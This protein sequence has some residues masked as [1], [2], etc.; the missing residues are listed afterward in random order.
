MTAQDIHALSGAY[1]VDALDDIER[2]RFEEHLAVCADCRDEVAGLRDS[3][4]MLASLTD[5][6]PPPEMRDRLLAG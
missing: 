1:A 5:T 6:P 4:W 2:A 3:A